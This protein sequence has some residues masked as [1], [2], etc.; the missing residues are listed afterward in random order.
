MLRVAPLDGDG[1]AVDG[2]A[3]GLFQRIEVGGGIAVI[4]VAG[5]VLGAAEV[6]D[7]LGR[8]GFARVHVRDD[9]DVAQFCRACLVTQKTIKDGWPGPASQLRNVAVA[10][11]SIT[12]TQVSPA[13]GAYSSH[14]HHGG[15][16]EVRSR[17][18]TDTCSP[19]C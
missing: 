6:E 10:S 12:T 16:G 13:F 2:D 15:N 17:R 8:R 11:S 4:D 1:R 14:S 3:L 9:A 19:D 18:E 7:A 5:L